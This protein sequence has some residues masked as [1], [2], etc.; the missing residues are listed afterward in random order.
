M[1]KQLNRGLMVSGRSSIPGHKVDSGMKAPGSNAKLAL[2]QH[3]LPSK[4]AIRGQSRSMPK[5]LPQKG[6]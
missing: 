5:F 4:S 6:G 1:A 2:G 3:Q